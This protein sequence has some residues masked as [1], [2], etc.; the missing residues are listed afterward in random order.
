MHADKPVLTHSSFSSAERKLFLVE[1]TSE[2]DYRIGATPSQAKWNQPLSSSCIQYPLCS[3]CAYY[4]FSGASL[5]S[6]W[7]S[8]PPLARRVKAPLFH[9]VYL[10][11]SSFLN[12]SNFFWKPFFFVCWFVNLLF[13]KRAIVSTVW[14]HSGWFAWFIQEIRCNIYYLFKAKLRQAKL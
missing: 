13:A 12:R 5:S 10:V 9:I 8:P 11:L 14:F 4:F 2:V 6:T 7:S 1:H 3:Q